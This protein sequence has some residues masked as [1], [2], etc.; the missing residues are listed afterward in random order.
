MWETQKGEGG[1]G[2][3]RS[4]KLSSTPNRRAGPSDTPCIHCMQLRSSTKRYTPNSIAR[5][6]R[7]SNHSPAQG[8]TLQRFDRAAPPECSGCTAQQLH[9]Q[10][11]LWVKLQGRWGLT[12]LHNLPLLRLHFTY[13]L[14]IQPHKQLSLP[15]HILCG[16]GLTWW[17]ADGLE[18]QCHQVCEWGQAGDRQTLQPPQAQPPQ[19]SQA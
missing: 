11:A 5:F 3:R 6:S 13:T 17:C 19:A 18:L 1:A 15:M 10:H 2:D 12:R 16:S 7:L 4:Y 14:L 9:F 8:W